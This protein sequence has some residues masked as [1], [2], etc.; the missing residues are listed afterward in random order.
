MV[1]DIEVTLENRRLNRMRTFR[2]SSA[3][4]V[5]SLALTAC[6]QSTP[7]VVEKIVE[8]VVVQTAIVEVEKLV[9]VTPTPE[10]VGEKIVVLGVE[11]SLPTFDPLNASDSRVD[12]ASINIYNALRQNIPGTT[13]VE[14]ELATGYVMSS[15]GLS[16]TFTLRPGIKF[17]DGSELD[18]ADV[19]YTVERMLALKVGYYSSLKNLTGAT[20]IDPLTVKLQLDAVFPAL[21]SALV[22]LYIVNSDLVKANVEAN[23]YG[24]KWLQNHDAGSGPYKLDSF[25]PE[26]QWSVVKHPEYFKGWEGAHVDKAIVRVIKEESTRRLAL[27]NAEIDWATITSADNFVAI[28]QLNGVTSFVNQT[29]NQFYFAMFTQ[30]KYLKDVRIRKALA[31]AYDYKGDVELARLGFAQIAQGAFPPSILCHDNTAPVSNQDLAKAKELMAE[32]G[33]PNGGFEFDMVYQGT[34]AQEV[35]AFQIMQASAAE[36]GIT[37][38]PLPAEWSA[39]VNLYS[40]PSTA[41]GLGTIWIY[42]SYADPDQFLGR[43]GLSSAFGNYNFAYYSN[44]AFDKVTTEARSELNP[45]KRCAMYKEAQTIWM[46]DQPYINGVV[47]QSLAAAR[48]YVKGY[49]WTPSHAFTQNLYLISVEDKYN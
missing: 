15:D 12:T 40:S 46:E 1:V 29:I 6:Q 5:L 45:E 19:V 32:A 11:G 41:P 14:N 25:E 18:S 3:V 31:L 2:Y 30:N 10:P 43:L 17:H 27:A 22:R 47:G 38:N 4:V 33:Y 24:Q 26:Q 35:Q 16:Y 23:D 8:K 34:N 7:Q 28:K 42:P 36:L 49:I 9:Q 13:D 21:P 44:E 20:A 37:V 48:D 39:K